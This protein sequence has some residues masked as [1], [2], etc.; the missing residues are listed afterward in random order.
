MIPLP[1]GPQ[2]STT[3]ESYVPG[4]TLWLGTRGYP[5]CMRCGHTEIEHGDFPVSPVVE[6]EHPS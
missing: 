2:A 1:P 5:C 6:F 4:G 3:C